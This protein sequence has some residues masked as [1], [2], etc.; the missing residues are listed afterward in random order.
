VTTSTL[1][2]LADAA[3][4]A[5]H[6]ADLFRFNLRGRIPD[7]AFAANG[8]GTIS[9]TGLELCKAGVFNGLQLLDSDLDAM[10]QRFAMLRDNGIFI[11]PFRLDHSWSV[12]SVIGWFEEL[13][14][15]HRVDTTDGLEKGFLVGD[16]RLTGSV[17][18][19]PAV[20]VNAIKRGALRPRS[21]ELGWYET[22]SGQELP[23]NFYGCAFVDI[24]AVEGLAPVQLSKSRPSTPHTITT[25][26]TEGPT[27]TPEQIARL[28]ALRA[29]TTLTAEQTA[30]RDELVALEAEETGDPVTAPSG[31]TDA[32]AESTETPGVRPAGDPDP[33]DSE[34]GNDDPEPEGGT[35]EPNA[36][37]SE[38]PPAE[39]GSGASA[40]EAGSPA[41]GTEAA[42]T[43]APAENL[44]EL[45]RLRAENRALLQAE[46]TRQITALRESGVI[47]QG[48][49]EDATYL[50]SHNSSE[51]RRR[52]GALLGSMTVSVT[53]RQRRGT[54]A[55]ASNGGGAGTGTTDGEIIR[56]GMD[57]EEVGPLWANLTSEERKAHQGEY[58]AWRKDRAGQK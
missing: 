46:T 7:S 11:P 13:Y 16:V 48:N 20:I 44:T 57:P 18:Y 51:V 47:V 27:M 25:L 8:D 40:P 37:T 10:V 26:S 33:A 9:I 14:V 5:R 6:G 42:P 23:L 58:D 24:P 22:N 55:L 54:T 15:E 56:L 39:A 31:A 38:T 50:L 32:A 30:E 34:G 41:G 2:S 3:V 1:P 36:A 49:E 29:L 21:S 45:A 52:A 4:D 53:L 35:G 12:L 28:A 19:A 43:G 17:D